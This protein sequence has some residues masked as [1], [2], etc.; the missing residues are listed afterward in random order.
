MLSP[1]HSEDDL[2]RQRGRRLDAFLKLIVAVTTLILIAFVAF[3]RFST[4]IGSMMM[5]ASALFCLYA[6]SQAISTTTV[7]MFFLGTA[8]LIQG[9]LGIARGQ[10]GLLS[11]FW[12]T[13][14]PA[15]ALGIGGRKAANW[16]LAMTV[17]VEL[18]S[19]EI[20][21]R[22]W[23]EPILERS[24]A[25]SDNTVA[26]TS[27]LI[28]MCVMFYL[29][30]RWY[31]A[32]TARTISEMA[33]RNE[34]LTQARRDAEDAN[35]VKGEFLATMSHEI[36]TPLNGV[37][38]MTAVLL[39]DDSHSPKTIESLRLISSSG[40]TLRSVIND[41][42]DFSKIESRQL[43]LEAMPVNVRDELR[44]VTQLLSPLAHA[45]NNRLG[46]EIDSAVP[47]WFTGDPTRIRQ[48]MLNLISNAVKFTH[49]GRI[50]LRI[51]SSEGSMTLVVSD[52]GI[53]MTQEAQKQLFVPFVQADN[54]T[55][56]RFGGTGLGLVIVQRLVEAM[57]GTIAVRSAPD[58]GTEF[59]VKIPITACAGP[60]LAEP[61]VAVL[62]LPKRVLVV[63]D[64]AINQVVA[65]R[66]IERLGHRIVIASNGAEA[67]GRMQEAVFDLV[68]MDCHMPVLDGFDATRAL[69]ARGVT[70]PIVALTAAASNEDHQRCVDA[71]MNDVLLKPIQ[72]SA[73]A[74]LLGQ[75]A[76]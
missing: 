15:I 35:R 20:I 56:R 9:S 19:I 24:V 55:T 26:G 64:N 7:V 5:L 43:T 71:G 53:G 59:T 23:V 14:L 52:N 6:R 57:R 62:A 25:P 41:V 16:V 37:L 46:L 50:E 73:L 44:V 2:E 60:S 68:L 49:D 13:M 72:L 51:A 28:G 27:T 54:S 65:A 30:S 12:L 66:L 31:D 33:R 75:T 32:E 38:G 39:E 58:H 17:F 76:A 36:R 61:S 74:N 48:V 1:A 11:L 42:L 18:A 8:A 67:L 47:A 22:K 70:V 10:A 4:A 34:E 21:K 69:R 3:G 40:D 29:I 45:N 63:E